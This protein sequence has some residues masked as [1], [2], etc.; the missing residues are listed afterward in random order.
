[1]SLEGTLETIALPDVLAL[2]S[3]TAKTGELRVDTGGGVGSVWFDG[4]R[5]AGFDV[6]GQRTAVDALFGLLR[7]EEGSFKFHA[8][9]EPVNPMEPEEVAPLME[10]AED[11]LNQWS[12]IA[13]AVPSV[14]C[15]LSLE[16]S[17]EGTVVLK[18]AQ[19]D[20]VTAIGGGRSVSEVLELRGLGEFEGCKAVKEL[21]DMHLVRVAEAGGQALPSTIL[22][23]PGAAERAE[24]A[25]PAAATPALVGLPRRWQEDDEGAPR[26]GAE[27]ADLSE[28]QGGTK[29]NAPEP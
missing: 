28:P 21:L 18:P 19:W 4:G 2:L 20:L 13:A 29:V 1:M 11:R 23:S 15:G 6:G 9:T 5:L 12:A 24:E 10:Q 17:V 26:E 16:A 22:R 25:V 3:V 8:G 27:V 14:S 7:L